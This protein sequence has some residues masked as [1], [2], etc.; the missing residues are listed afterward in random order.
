MAMPFSLFILGDDPALK[1]V[2]KEAAGLPFGYDVTDDVAKATVVIA[3]LP[4]ADARLDD[5]EKILSTQASLFSVLV[6][7]HGA[8]E[9]DE[10]TQKNLRVTGVFHKPL[11]VPSFLDALATHVRLQALKTPRVL[12]KDVAF[13]PQTRL[14]ESGKKNVELSEREAGFLLAVLDAGPQGLP[15]AKAMTDVWRFHREAESHAVDTAAYRL[16]Q[17]LQEVGLMGAFVIENAVYYWRPEE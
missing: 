12:T 3:S 6:Y 2:L 4:R 15:R 7:P 13:N 8:A 17:K 11:H 16:R 5:V 9:P 1:A 10:D 14:I